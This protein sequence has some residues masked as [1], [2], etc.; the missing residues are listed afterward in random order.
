[1][2]LNQFVLRH[3]VFTAKFACFDKKN[4]YTLDDW[5]AY[6]MDVFQTIHLLE[7]LPQRLKLNLNHSRNRYII[8]SC[9]MNPQ[10][11]LFFSTVEPLNS[12][13]AYSLT[14]NPF[15]PSTGL[16]MGAILFFETELERLELW[17]NPTPQQI[18]SIQRKG[19]YGDR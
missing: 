4:T 16:K 7:Y 13:H 10:N 19:G 8:Q 12:I 17:F 9:G 1:M 6:N 5:N 3:P 2:G 11:K 15:L 14:Q 18:E